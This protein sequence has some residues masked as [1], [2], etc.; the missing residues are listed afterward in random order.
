M[1][2]EERSVE[3]PIAVLTHVRQNL[4]EVRYKEGSIITPKGL[5]EIHEAQQALCGNTLH[6]MLYI[7]PVGVGYEVESMQHA[8]WG[9]DEDP[10]VAMAVAAVSAEIQ[11]VTQLYF[12]YF[13]Q[14]FPTLVTNDREE[15]LAWLE[16]QLTERSPTGLAAQALQDLGRP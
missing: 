5:H 8:Y 9:P 15:A 3:V 2:F 11:M 6:A 10:V 16:A 13:P 12:T 1:R 7:I 4:V 14:L